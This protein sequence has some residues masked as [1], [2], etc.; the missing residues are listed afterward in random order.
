MRAFSL[1]VVFLAG[2]STYDW[3]AMNARQE[4]ICPAKGGEII[5]R[6]NF[7]LECVWPSSDG[8]SP[9]SDSSQC[10]GY[11]TAS[12]HCSTDQSEFKVRNCVDHLAN[13]VAV[14]ECVD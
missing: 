13:G 1:L 6:T 2:C 9:C 5:Q 4:R 14:S 7:R 11:C 12:G 8:G 10:Q 3:Q